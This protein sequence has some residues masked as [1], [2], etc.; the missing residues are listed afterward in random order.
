MIEL[1]RFLTTYKEGIILILSVVALISLLRFARAWLGSRRASFGM[2]REVSQSQ[3]RSS[4]TICA[5]AVLLLITQL[6]LVSVISIKF[7]GV[8]QVATPTVSLIIT[9]TTPLTEVAGKVATMQGYNITQTAMAATGCIPGQL[10][11]TSPKPGDEVSGSVDLKGTINIRNLGFYKY[12]YQQIG[13]EEW[14]PIAAGS[15][16]VVDEPLAGKWNTAQLV[17]GNYYL[18]LTV[19][20][21]Q[22]NLLKPCV[23][24]VKVNPS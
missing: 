17:P 16:A 12:E 9:P 11:W 24:E 19:S 13:K 1:L 5:L 7:P 6:M 15:K 4:L 2:E 22:N 3:I 18:R 20:D 14:I 8:A 10:E 21:N 23:I